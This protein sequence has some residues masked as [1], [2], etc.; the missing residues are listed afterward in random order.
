[1]F[2]DH[3]I[4]S[5]MHAENILQTLIQTNVPHLYNWT[6]EGLVHGPNSGILGF[7]GF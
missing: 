1:M 3:P 6:F 4:K 5:Y 7:L 2:T